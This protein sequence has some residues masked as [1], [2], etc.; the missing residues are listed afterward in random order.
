[1]PLNLPVKDHKLYSQKLLKIYWKPLME[2]YIFG[3][4]KNKFTLKFILNLL[5]SNQ[6]LSYFWNKIRDSGKCTFAELYVGK[7]SLGNSPSGKSPLGNCPYTNPRSLRT[8][9]RYRSFLQINV[10]LKVGNY[11][12]KIWSW[13]EDMKA[14]LPP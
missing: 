3:S 1:M 5:S 13:Y 4:K 14:C 12:R 6:S 7:M 10:Q 9:F 8:F 11:G 2:I